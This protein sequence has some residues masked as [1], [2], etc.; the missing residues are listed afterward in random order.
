MRAANTGDTNWMYEL[1]IGIFC[2]G[3]VVAKIS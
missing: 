3:W 2:G 1:V